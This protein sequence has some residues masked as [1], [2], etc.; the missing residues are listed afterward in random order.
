VRRKVGPIFLFCLALPLGGCGRHWQPF[1]EP[2]YP[3][4]AIA[5][6]LAFRECLDKYPNEQYALDNISDEQLRT[7]FAHNEQSGLDGCM[8][9]QGWSSMS[10]VMLPTP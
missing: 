5:L 6:R 4:Y 10:D 7:L 1:N 9:A 3:S 2:Q 8:R